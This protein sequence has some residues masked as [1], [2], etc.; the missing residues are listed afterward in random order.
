[1]TCHMHSCSLLFSSELGRTQTPSGCYRGLRS[2]CTCTS[3]SVHAAA[4]N[5]HRT[6]SLGTADIAAHSSGARRSET[7][8]PAWWPGLLAV[9][10]RGGGAGAGWGR[11]SGVA[12]PRRHL[13]GRTRTRE[14]WGGT[15]IQARAR[16]CGAGS[17]V[18][19]QRAGRDGA[20]LG[21]VSSW[22]LTIPDGRCRC[23]VET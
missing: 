9:S 7:R 1:M 6:G 8:V 11:R 10:P 16:V 14:F 23:H 4:A 13:G 21:L 18:G 17:E 20:G 12:S 22:R 3:S 5:Q 2:G 15:G 19:S